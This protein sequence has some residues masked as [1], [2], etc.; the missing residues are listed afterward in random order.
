[1]ENKILISVIV[2]VYGVEQY[3]TKCVESLFTQTLSYGVEYIFVDDCTKDRSL[4]KLNEVIAKYPNRKDFV[5]IV[6]HDYNK[7]LVAARKTGVLE[8]SGEYL[9]H[10]DSDDWMEPNMLESLYNEAVHSKAQIIGCDL[11]EDYDSQEIIK[12]Q[13]F[14]LNH[15][16][17][18]NA[19]LEGIS[20][21]SYLCIRMVE[22]KFY[23]RYGMHTPEDITLY[24]DLYT[25]FFLHY[26]ASR[27]SYVPFPLYH[28]RQLSISAMT[29]NITLKSWKS[30]SKA[31]GLIKGFLESKSDYGKYR[32]KMEYSQLMISL[33]LITRVDIYNPQLWRQNIL[34]YSTSSLPIYKKFSIWM[35]KNKFDKI[36]FWYVSLLR[37]CQKLIS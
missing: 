13:K 4:E 10:C 9:I 2:P 18:L 31:L 26:H 5:R 24:E 17:S 15:T 32:Q 1:M 28:Y 14:I 27:V 21:K 25:S 8:S 37:Q 12:K 6:R 33:Y 36:N 11:F 29:K 34:P 23:L 20:L 19:I 16:E 35:V 7:G 22:R 30:A 3:I